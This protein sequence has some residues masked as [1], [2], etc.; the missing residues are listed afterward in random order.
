MRKDMSYDIE[1]PENKARHEKIN[2]LLKKAGW[3]IQHYKS[4]NVYSS[5]GVAVEFFEMGKVGQADYTLFVNGQPVGIIEAK[6]EGTPLIGKEPQTGKYSEGL[7][8]E[9]DKVDREL[10]F[11]YESTG[12]ITHFT[13]KWDP[14]SRSREVFAFHRPETIER[15]IKNSKEGNLRYNLSQCKKYKNSSLW[16][17]QKRA[18]ENVKESMA[19][20][21]P[22]A[23]IQMATG[24]GK[25]FTAVNICEDLIKNGKAERILFLVDRSNLGDQTLQEF[26]NFEVAGDGRKFT[27]LHSVQHLKG[28]VLYD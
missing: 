19:Q 3:D 25:T 7:S 10:P 2:P 17:V 23:L 4:A 8:E 27:D 6:K 16:E 26:E 15:W 20:G 14:K 5:K 13:N 12:T 1:T 28:N 11:L 21:K 22:R 9:Y 24:S 18:I